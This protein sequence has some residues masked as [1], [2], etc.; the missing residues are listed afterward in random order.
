MLAGDSNNR[1]CVRGINDA[2]SLPAAIAEDVAE[3]QRRMIDG[4]AP[5][6]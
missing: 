5:E 4:R 6:S 2:K 1:H 3:I